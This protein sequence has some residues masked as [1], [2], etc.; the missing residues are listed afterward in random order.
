M[1]DKMTPKEDTQMEKLLAAEW[2]E[3]WDGRRSMYRGLGGAAFEL[4][5]SAAY[6]SF[7]WGFR[8]AYVPMLDKSKKAKKKNV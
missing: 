1:V 8:N 6:L 4:V 5:K 2:E 7:G 3:Y